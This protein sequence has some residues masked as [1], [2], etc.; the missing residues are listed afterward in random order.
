MIIINES[1]KV[2]RNARHIDIHYHHI[3]NLIEKKIIMISHISINK[4]TVND[5][6]KMLLLNK[7]KK[8]IELI[9]ISK[10]EISN[11]KLSNNKSDKINDN[12]KNNENFVTNYYKKTEEISFKIKKT[13]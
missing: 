13:K 7:F 3:Q 11:S 8:F 9:K 10:I 1:K 5:L 12:D 2:I 6:T 4:M